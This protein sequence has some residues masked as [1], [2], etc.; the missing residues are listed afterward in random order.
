MS[1][2]T[3]T[4]GAAVR[5]PVPPLLFVAPLVVTLALH[6]WVLPLGIP[7]QPATTVAGVVLVAAGVAFSLSGLASV[8]RHHTTM[9][10]HHPVD[11]LV[12]SGAYRISRN[13]MYA[14]HLVAY[15]GAG[16]WAA[17]WWPLIALPLCI[18]ATNRL[19]IEAEEAYLTS[20]LGGEY[21]A[22]RQRVR[23]WF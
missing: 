21:R 8:V 20:R 11:R 7:G 4:R 2:A 23:R 18:L 13:P 14:G 22:Y 1:T 10:P 19:V 12:T 9:V 6:V 16:L 3:P 17:T 15:L 5:F